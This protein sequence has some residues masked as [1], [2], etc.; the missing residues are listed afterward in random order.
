MHQAQGGVIFV[1]SAPQD[2][3]VFFSTSTL[4]LSV[5]QSVLTDNYASSTNDVRH[6]A[7]LLTCPCPSSEMLAAPALR[8]A[9]LRPSLVVFDR[10]TACC[11]RTLALHVDDRQIHTKLLQ[12][13]QLL[14]F[15]LDFLETTLPRSQT[16]ERLAIRRLV[17]FSTPT[18]LPE[19][20]T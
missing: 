20:A 5:V 6:E 14:V 2:A 9:S 19:G 3:S 18:R 16:T 10:A 8:T 17:L 12:L 13:A 1:Q 7:A 15:F 4:A 11:E